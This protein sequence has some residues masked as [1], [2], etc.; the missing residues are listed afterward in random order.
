MTVAIRAA[1]DRLDF[2][3]LA[4]M[5][6]IALTVSALLIADVNLFV[7]EARDH[8]D[9]AAVA[10]LAEAGQGVR[11][12]SHD[13]PVWDTARLSEPLYLKDFVFTDK[14][15][16]AKL[17]FLDDSTIELGEN[18]LIEV[19]QL[20]EH[21]V[22]NVIKGTLKAR[23]GT[24]DAQLLIRING[25]KELIRSA[26]GAAVELKVAPGRPAELKVLQGKAEVGAA[27]VAVTANQ[28]AEISGAEAAPVVKDLA[29][30]LSAPPHG[31]TLKDPL[32]SGVQLAWQ[33]RAGPFVIEVARD[34]SFRNVIRTETVDG[35]T[36][37]TGELA[38]GTYHWRVRPADSTEASEERRFTVSVSRGPTPYLPA[39]GQTVTD[40]SPKMTWEALPDAR[41]YEIQIAADAE[42]A[43][44]V[45]TGRAQAPTLRAGALQDGAYYWRVK[46][47]GAAIWGPTA[48]FGVEAQAVEPV[49]A[50]AI[51]KVK[52]QPP[53]VPKRYDILIPRL[54]KRP[55]RWDW[56]KSLIE[57]TAYAEEAAPRQA[58]EWQAVE[59]AI[60]Y[61]VE[62]AD[63]ADFRTRLIT[64]RVEAPRWPVHDLAAGEY[65]LRVAGIDEDGELGP[66]SEASLVVVSKKTSAPGEEASALPDPVPSLR[67]PT[68]IAPVDGE[69]LTLASLLPVV[70]F[71]W[72]RVGGAATYT[73]QVATDADFQNV[74]FEKRTRGL[75]LGVELKPRTYYW[76][77]R[78]HRTVSEPGDWG[79]PNRFE[80]VH[81][82]PVTQVNPEVNPD[83][84][85][86]P[87]AAK[88]VS[89]GT[90]KLR[91]ERG[92]FT[93]TLNPSRYLYE[94]SQADPRVKIDAKLLNSVGA[95]GFVSLRPGLAVE[96]GFRRTSTVL[97]KNPGDNAPPGQD[98]VKVAPYFGHAGVR[99]RLGDDLTAAS[100]FLDLGVGYLVRG[101]T[102][103]SRN[104]DQTIAAKTVRR[105]SAMATLAG[106]IRFSQS[107]DV[108]TG[109]TGYAKGLRAFLLSHHDFASPG[110]G[111]EFGFD[112]T[113]ESG[114][115]TI[116]QQS[117]VLGLG[118]NH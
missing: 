56:L 26:S 17:A 71:S 27:K 86:A 47:L 94:S 92:R 31:A 107:F 72:K 14:D 22:L 23:T 7:R 104:A 32:S 1:N 51:P 84:D 6:A 73:F 63:D 18:T 42:F 116:I 75:D 20:E 100:P 110:L 9:K 91:P 16:S 43:N 53:V 34:Q 11:R 98:P 45:W 95:A 74:V 88:P 24:G 40:L 58:L 78:T 70:S 62:I 105:Q 99:W 13:L 115:A 55:S 113:K 118:Y 5:G 8:S 82:A 41:S 66:Y 85:P 83:P 76:R 102:E 61:Q 81:T 67:P 52:L 96:G 3:L 108:R 49:T 19:Q 39:D 90:P 29:V 15:A 12:R 114:D 35:T 48:R 89:L 25:Q 44:V 87:A 36:W 97:F 103:F 38:A 54:E 93:L 28:T 64:E 111:A 77:M 59:G 112:F 69:K 109:V 79:K 117:L 50:P 30:V 60:A 80:V 68:L 21:S 33:G 2:T 57:S 10:R 106:G 37:S 65:Y 4:L 46:D 101:I